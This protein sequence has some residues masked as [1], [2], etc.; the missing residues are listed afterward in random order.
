MTM[1]VILCLSCD[2]QPGLVARVTA[3]LFQEGL[4]IEE[5]HQFGD[6]KSGQFFMRIKLA[7]QKK[8]SLAA[9]RRN[10]QPIAARFG[11]R[12]HFSDADEKMRVAILVSKWDHCLMDLLHRQRTGRLPMQVRLIVSNHANARPLARQAAIAFHH[13]PAAPASADSKAKTSAKRKAEA[14]LMRLLAKERIQL[15]VL[16]RYMQILSAEFVAAWE[17]RIINIHHS[18]LPSFKGASPYRQAFERGVK[19]IGATAHY[20]TAALDEGPIIAQDV[21]PVRHDMNVQTMTQM[22]WE[23]EQRV[24]ARALGWHLD[25]RILLNNG[26]TIVF[27]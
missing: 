23:I 19:M 7:A 18:F 13:I 15:V 10:F 20:V 16:A 8:I 2:D 14:R 22:G 1:R 6:A 4:N 5:S 12:A 24:L 11:M 27:S 17:G 3:Q 26:K 9:L 25:R 21:V